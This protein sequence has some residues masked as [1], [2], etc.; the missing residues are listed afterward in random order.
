MVFLKNKNKQDPTLANLSGIFPRHTGFG[1]ANTSLA[2][3]HHE[4]NDVTCRI[5]EKLNSHVI[6]IN[7]SIKFIVQ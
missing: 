3:G 5:S 4:D 2:S 6:L 7:I 1:L